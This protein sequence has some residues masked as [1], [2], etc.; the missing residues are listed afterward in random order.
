MF[1]SYGD[2]PRA[3]HFVIDGIG[4]YFYL[5]ID[6]KERNKSLV[7]KGG[8]FAS[9]STLIEGTPSPF[10]AQTITSCITATVKYDALIKLSEES[11]EWATFLRKIL[12]NLVLKKEKR[13]SDFL[14][15][16]AT[17]RYVLFFTGI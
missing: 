16:S 6:G 3:V 9:V 7:K 14:L 11:I 4:R 13:E 2:T 12:E 10:F 1:F 15:L 8:A 17:D 5:D